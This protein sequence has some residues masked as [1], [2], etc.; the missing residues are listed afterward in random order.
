M[1]DA[2][3]VHIVGIG[4]I[5]TSAVAKWWLDREAKVS[6]SDLVKS[7]ITDEVAKAGA[8]VKIGHFTE[9]LPREADLLIYSAAIPA[10]NPERV[11]A[12]ELGVVELSYSEFLG[13][14]AKEKKTIAV[15]GT[16]GKSTTTAMIAKILI[17][18]DYDPTVILGTK[19]PD[20]NN[21]NLRI[22]KSDWL[23]IE[24][25]EHMA[26]MLHIIPNIA[27]ITNIEE[28]HLDFYRDLD[29]ITQTF[30]KWIDQMG[31]C[32]KTIL[33]T[34]DKN[35][36]TLNTTDPALFKVDDRTIDKG[37]QSFDVAGVPVE[38][39]IPGTFNA[40]NAA[41]ALTAAHLAGV[42]DDHALSSLKSFKG[43]WRRFEHIGKWKKA[44]IYSDYAHHPTAV[45]GSIA[46][47]K[48][49]FPNRRLVIVFQPHQHSRTHEL[50]D[51]F[52][53]SFTEA[54]VVIMNKIYEVAGRTEEK[55]ESS[56]D[57]VDAI[58]LHGH[59]NV[60][61][62]KDLQDAQKQLEELVQPNDIIVIMGAGNIDSLAREL[63]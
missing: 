18:A 24:A 28:D 45:Q 43:T 20:L 7:D 37:V 17:E 48:E 15:S 31:V 4:G 63:V 50:F 2:K 54:D 19:S 39:T 12:Q 62:A 58:T 22:G 29:H 21:S 13:A 61:H 34:T 42:Q 14:L 41:A 44:D 30:Q 59:K 10:T 5:G 33:N 60:M 32:G 11:A 27:V 1:M 16:N 51:E 36:M 38:L 46:A 40:Q 47:F 53:E 8:T 35:S 3:Y 57:L 55:F 23:V 52:A 56:Q 26:N 6:G 49:F 9:N 25:C